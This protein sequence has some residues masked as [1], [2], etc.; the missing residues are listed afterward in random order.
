MRCRVH[1]RLLCADREDTHLEHKRLRAF[2]SWS[3]PFHPKVKPEPAVFTFTGFFF[4]SPWCEK[5]SDKVCQLCQSHH[6]SGEDIFRSVH[7]AVGIEKS[8]YQSEMSSS[9]SARLLEG[10]SK[11]GKCGREGEVTIWKHFGF[12]QEFRFTVC[13]YKTVSA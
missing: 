11:R 3:H 8:V 4:F 13:R 2:H 1:N 7:S 6:L 10:I 9:R 12:L 5:S